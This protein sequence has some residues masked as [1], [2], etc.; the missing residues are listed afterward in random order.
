MHP[1]FKYR[2]IL[3]PEDII[4]NDISTVPVTGWYPGLGKRKYNSIFGVLWPVWHLSPLFPSFPL[5]VSINTEVDDTT[6][7]VL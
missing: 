7:Y 1:F 3:I 4:V 6:N 5:E 2:N